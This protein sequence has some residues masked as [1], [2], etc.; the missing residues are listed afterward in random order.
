MPFRD[1]TLEGIK[2]SPVAVTSLVKLPEGYRK[3]R[4]AQHPVNPVKRGHY[5]IAGAHSA[6][7]LMKGPT[8]VTAVATSVPQQSSVSTQE[9]PTGIDQVDTSE[10]VGTAAMEAET[11]T[12]ESTTSA[13]VTEKA[14]ETLL[15]NP[16]QVILTQGG[17][18]ASENIGKET[19]GDPIF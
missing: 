12:V 17:A 2:A 3:T 8:A 19:S 5:W 14:K 10:E 9:Q 15:R 18:L 4:F 1:D 16:A 6:S 13:G 11:S 7:C